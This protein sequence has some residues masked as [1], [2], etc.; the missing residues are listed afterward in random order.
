LK[1]TWKCCGERPAVF[2]RKTDV[3]DAEW[4]ADLLRHGPLRASFIMPVAQRALRDITRFRS[5]FVREWATLAGRGQKVLEDAN[6]KL[7]AVGSDVMGVSGRAM[8]AALIWS[9]M[10]G[11]FCEG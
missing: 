7:A 6:P 3:G 5:T 4:I 9:L 8:L 1:A 2:E 10:L 11:R